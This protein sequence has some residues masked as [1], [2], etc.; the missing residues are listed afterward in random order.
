MKTIIIYDSMYGSTEKIAKAIAGAFPP[1]DVQVF[2]AGETDSIPQDTGL[3]VIGSPTQGG[4]QTKP[5]QDFMDKVLTSPTNNTKFA[6]FDTRLAN[7]LVVIFGYAAQRIADALKKKGITLILPPERFIVK[8][9]KGP[10][11]EGELER[12]AAWGK[13]LAKIVVG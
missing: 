11:K 6:V 2:R 4:R 13:E 1:G 9:A 10:L 3:L 7:K 8:G 12:A 5:L